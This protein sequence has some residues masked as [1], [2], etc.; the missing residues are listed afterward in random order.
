MEKLSSTMIPGPLKPFD[1]K[2]ECFKRIRWDET[3]GLRDVGK[4]LYG[5]IY[6]R[7]KDGC[8]QKDYALANASW[9][10]E[11]FAAEGCKFPGQGIYA[12]EK[13]L[14]GVYTVPK[15]M[16][17]WE[18][19]DPNYA[20]SVVKRAAKHLGAWLVGICELDRRFLYSHS[21]HLITREHVPL[22]I[23]P[24]FK[25]AVVMAFEENYDM[26]RASPSYIAES[27]VGLAYSHMAFTAGSLAQFIR[28]LGY[29]AIPNGN[30][31]SLSTALAIKAGLG[32]LG[33]NGLLIT[34]KYGPRVRISKVFT[35]MPLAV[36]EPIEFG[37]KRFCDVCKKCAVHCP[38]QAILY[39]DQ[40]AEAIN[41]ST[42]PGAL[43]WP[44]DAE[45]CIKFWA[46]NMGTCTNCVMVCPFNK[47]EGVIHD[48]ARWTIKGFPFLSSSLVKVDDLLGYGK[49]K[50]AEDFWLSG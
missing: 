14:R 30:D 40:T 37:V 5:P 39:G 35:D 31:T 42:N 22:V 46:A 47:P 48:L 41:E 4:I 2:Y 8:T 27:T 15:D 1:Q 9:F 49:R 21:Y 24:E 32:E 18:N 36:D 11:L 6:P 45:K 38:G 26:L 17:V 16:G 7:A 19:S 10:L 13:D 34:K 29:K 23:P 20:S 50:K 3:Q 33:R 43:K 25:Y 44:I 12:W 28:G